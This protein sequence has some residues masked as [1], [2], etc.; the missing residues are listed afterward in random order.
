MN[1]ISTIIITLN[2]EKNIKDCI[3]SVLWTDEIIV[4]DSFST[5]KT[6]SICKKFP[7]VKV[8]TKKWMGYARTKNW[9]IKK[10]KYEWILSIDADERITPE[11]KKEIKQ[12]LKNPEYDGYLIPRKNFYFGKWI[13]WGGN[14]PDYQ[15]RL[16][17]KGK[18]EFRKVLLHEGVRLFKGAPGK[19]K[20]PM[21]HFTY[22]SVN[23]YF[24]RFKKY[25]ELE[26]EILKQKNVKINIFT[27]F[28]YFIFYPLKK[29]IS[30]YIF[31]LGFLDGIDGLIVLKLNNLTKLIAFYKYILYKKGRER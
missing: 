24:E 20:N 9:G 7:K 19:L 28:Y 8:Y 2:E 21:L 13:K 10:A 31:K 29:F 14:Y 4:I 30:R 11:L 3:K 15:L 27:I 23:D 26:K 5:D 17:R 1:K 25:T 16:F 18:G 6:V 12:I 22:N